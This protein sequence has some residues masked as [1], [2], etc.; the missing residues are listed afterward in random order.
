MEN[1]IAFRIDHGAGDLVGGLLSIRTLLSQSLAPSRNQVTGRRG[2]F[3][4][5]QFAFSKK[6]L[7]CRKPGAW[8][9]R[10]RLD[11][12]DDDDLNATSQILKQNRSELE[13]EKS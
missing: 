9:H 6:K 7:K 12:I 3:C 2:R 5:L 4:N 8:Y 10:R 11:G 1:S 13:K